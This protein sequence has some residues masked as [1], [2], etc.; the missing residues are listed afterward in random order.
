VPQ[1]REVDYT[2]RTLSSSLLGQAREELGAGD[3]AR[4]FESSAALLGLSRHAESDAW[5]ALGI[6]FHLSGGWWPSR[7][8]Q[9]EGPGKPNRGEIV[10][11]CAQPATVATSNHRC[12]ARPHA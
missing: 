3:V 2:L 7:A 5:L 4:K 6:M 10:T 1:V 9:G 8:G 12:A 11:P